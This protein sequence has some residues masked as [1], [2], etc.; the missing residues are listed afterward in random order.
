MWTFRLLVIVVLTLMFSSCE[1]K[2]LYPKKEKSSPK[3]KKTNSVGISDAAD[4]AT[5]AL[6]LQVL[7]KTKKKIDKMYEKREKQIEKIEKD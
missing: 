5:G 7:E 2:P 1:Q 3:G 6:P 4:Y